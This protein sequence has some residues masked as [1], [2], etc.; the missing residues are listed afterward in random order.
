LL[1]YRAPVKFVDSCDVDVVAGRGGNGAIAFRREKFVPFGG[2]SGGDGGRGGDV[3]FVADEGL[4]TLL[5]LT[6]GRTLRAPHGEQGHG[7]DMYGRGAEDLI[8]RVPVG[9][10]VKDRETGELLF[11]LDRPD[12]RVIVAKGGKGGRGNIHFATPYDRAPRRSEPGEEGEEKKYRL[13]LKIMADVGLLGF[14]NVGKSTFI[15]AVSRAR[16]KVADYPFT[17]LTPHLGVVRIGDEAT[18]VIADIPGLIPGASEG[19]GLGHRFLKHVE[20]TRALLHLV[21][22]D[23]GEDRDPLSDYTALMNELERFDPDLAKRPQIVA[24]TKA[25]LPEVRE[26]FES[27]K[28]RFTKKKIPI[29][30]ISAATGDGVRELS[31]ALYKLVTGKREVEDW[32]VPAT[33]G[34]GDWEAASPAPPESDLAL[35]P[36]PP[37][38]PPRK[39]AT[40]GA[41]RPTEMPVFAVTKPTKKKAAKKAAATKSAP[42]KKTATSKKKAAPKKPAT[43]KPKK[44]VTKKPAPKRAATKAVSGDPRARLRGRVV[45]SS[46]PRGVGRGLGR[47]PQQ[48]KKKR[49]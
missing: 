9:T 10:Q 37:P 41:I 7:K 31:V 21:T 25:D 48:N 42:A 28:A 40:N 32:D 18:M 44:A 45:E 34:S 4:S 11:D 5:D 24:M 49:A 1:Y 12:S 35:P 43:K 14:P 33:R 29:H 36:S 39:A 47:Q 8:V 19:A 38:P 2:P 20:R 15:R 27:V 13:E 30:L 46:R 16:P 17:T 6:Y 23:F 3:V 22:L 26:A